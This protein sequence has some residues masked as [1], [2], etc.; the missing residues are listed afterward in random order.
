M[1]FFSD[2]FLP[3]DFGILRVETSKLGG[4]GSLDWLEICPVVADG[5]PAVST[6]MDEKLS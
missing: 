2:D 1:H 5:F 6:K 4:F 3:N